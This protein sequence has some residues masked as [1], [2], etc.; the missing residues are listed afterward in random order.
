MNE[1]YKETWYEIAESYTDDGGTMTIE[2]TDTLEEAKECASNYDFSAE[3]NVYFIFIDKWQLSDD[4]T[5]LKDRGFEALITKP[6][7]NKKA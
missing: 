3:P 2:S 7:K 5:P 4:W 6:I 1:H